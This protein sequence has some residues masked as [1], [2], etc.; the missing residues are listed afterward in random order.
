MLSEVKI[1]TICENSVPYP[2]RGLLGEHGLSMLLEAG[3]KKILFDTGAGLTL[4]QNARTL[5]LDLNDL[6]AVVLSH[7]HFDHTGGLKALLE[8]AGPLSI[9]AHPDIFGAKYH[10]REGQEPRNI[11]L[12]WDREELENLG[13]RFSLERSSQ[14]IYKGVVLTG[15][16]PRTQE[17]EKDLKG[18]LV[19]KKS[20]GSFCQDPLEDDQSIIVETS[21]GSIVLLGCAHAGLINT[22]Q[23]VRNLTGEQ[24]IYACIGGTHLIEASEERMEYTLKKLSPFEL[25]KIAPCHCTGFRA[26]FALY[27]AF[28]DRFLTHSAGTVFRFGGS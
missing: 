24:H 4:V 12:P 10:L 2:G 16:I 5:G 22:F 23:H 9:Y 19:L 26:S 25:E 13:A 11:S 1:T 21:V 15:E 8:I 28:G 3:G 17:W 7:G 6:D 27:Q 14:E 18:E 20:D